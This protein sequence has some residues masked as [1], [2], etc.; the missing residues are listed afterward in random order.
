[1][2]QIG[3]VVSEKIFKIICIYLQKISKIHY[4]STKPVARVI[5]Y[6]KM[7]L[8]FKFQ[9]FCEKCGIIG[10]VGVFYPY[11]LF[12]ATVAMLDDWQDHLIKY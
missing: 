10:E 3:S 1:M 2:D 12:I 9:P 7:D 11:D 5:P 6:I 4:V 8:L